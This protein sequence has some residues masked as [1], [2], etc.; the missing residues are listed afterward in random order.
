MRVCGIQASKKIRKA[1]QHAAYMHQQCQHTCI[2]N[3][4]THASTMPAYMHHLLDCLLARSKTIDNF[5]AKT[6]GNFKA[7]TFGIL[8]VSFFAVESSCVLYSVFLGVADA[9]VD[10]VVDAASAA[11]RR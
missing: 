1:C 8:A 7:K 4:S 11:T 9:V 2:N 3:A 10:A 6:I 5:K